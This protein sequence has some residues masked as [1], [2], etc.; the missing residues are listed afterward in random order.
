MS[1]Y[2]IWNPKSR[3]GKLA[4]AWPEIEMALKQNVG[5][6]TAIPTEFSGHATELTRFALEKKATTV[7]A[8]GGDGTVNEVVNGFFEGDE[9]IGS[10]CKLAVLPHGTGGD[11]KRTLNLPQGLDE[12]CRIIKAGHATN[13]DVGT[14]TFVDHAGKKR[15]RYFINIASCGISGVVDRL[16]NNGSKKFGKLSYLATTLRASMQYDNQ[17]ISVVLDHDDNNAI[18][19]TVNTL[20]IANGKYFG[21]GMKIAPH[22]KLNDG[23]FSVVS[24]G[25]LSKAEMV[26]LSPKIFSGSHESHDKVSM[27]EAKHISVTPLSGKVEL[28]V[29]GESPGLLPATFSIIPNAIPII[30]MGS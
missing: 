22:A 6:F 10:K 5:A 14:V 18:S 12:L 4:S 19:L 17:R 24:L 3:G 11:F 15:K 20:A 2:V 7:V 1:I 13:S 30:G 9:Y 27:R 28:D 25:D 16:L 23:H 8:V 29:D 21:G 26:M